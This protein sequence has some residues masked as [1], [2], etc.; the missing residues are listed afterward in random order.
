MTVHALNPCRIR[1]TLPAP[2]FWAPY[3][4][5]VSAHPKHRDLLYNIYK[6]EESGY[7]LGDHCCDS[8]TRRSHMKYNDE[9][10]IQY[11]IEKRGQD[12]EIQRHFAVA[13]RS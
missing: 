4:A 7:S 1:G 3:V 5:I 9:Y 2:I 8:G 6:A 10:Q 13:E 12:Q 11:D